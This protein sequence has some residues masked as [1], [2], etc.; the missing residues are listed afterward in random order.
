MHKTILF[1]SLFFGFPTAHADFETLSLNNYQE[2]AKVFKQETEKY[3][4]KEVLFIF[5]LDRTMIHSIDCLGAKDDSN[6]FFRFEKTVEN[7]PASITS[8]LLIEILSNL[9]KENYPVMALTARRDKILKGTLAQLEDRLILSEENPASLRI[10]FPTAPSYSNR[11]KTIKFKQQG[12]EGILN[13]T[14]VIKRGVSMASGANK[15][16]ALQA[17]TKS[18]GK[19]NTF[20][21]LIFID[22]DK[23]NIN[24]L[25]KAYSDSKDSILIIHYTEFEKEKETKKEK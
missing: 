17:F 25:E 15:G 1:L 24:H 3:S 14:L 18:L 7:C 12:R 4:S 23:K 5:D 8:P 10:T 11:K 20:K 9:Q 21:K 16:L 13:K 2:I 22:D 6:K 19:K